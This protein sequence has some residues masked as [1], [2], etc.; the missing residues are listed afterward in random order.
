MSLP[1][2]RQLGGPLSNTLPG[3]DV[4]SVVLDPEAETRGVATVFRLMPK[5]QKLFEQMEQMA[6]I[7]VT[8]SGVLRRLLENLKTPDELLAQIS[9]LEQQA[10]ELHH[11]A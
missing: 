2:Q 11:D 3:T 1:M 9:K 10:D 8:C 5:Q 6:Q 4:P 7:A